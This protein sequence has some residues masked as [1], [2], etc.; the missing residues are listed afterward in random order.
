M[1]ANHI[2]APNSSGNNKKLIEI[3][4][5]KEKGSI[6]DKIYNYSL[7]NFKVVLLNAQSIY[8]HMGIRE[9]LKKIHKFESMG[10]IITTYKCGE[11]SIKTFIRA[12][13]IK[14]KIYRIFD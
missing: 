11:K 5:S 12:M 3:D 1:K 14:I 9:F 2:V 10:S 13:L 8:R 4:F 6:T 7:D